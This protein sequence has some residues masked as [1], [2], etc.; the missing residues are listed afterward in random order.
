LPVP[1]V[2]GPRSRRWEGNP[3]AGPIVVEGAT[4]GDVLVVEIRDIVV[5]DQGT[6]CIFP[7][8]GPLADSARYPDCHGPFT[9][10]IRHL[11]G[12]SGP[13]SDGKGVFDERVTWDLNPHI[14]TIGTVP[15]RPVSAGSDTVFGQGP[16]GGNL[17]CRD[18]RKGARV[19]LPVAVDGAFLYVGDVHA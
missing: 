7:G 4:A 2:L 19:L 1:E 17:D 10:I 16:H 9:K 3:C 18:L 15:E 14:G 6:T 11:P 5:D 8:V 13:T 12:P